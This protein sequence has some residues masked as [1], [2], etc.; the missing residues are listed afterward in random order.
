MSDIPHDTD[1]EELR[2]KILALF[3][4]T[5]SAGLQVADSEQ[6][7]FEQKC[8]PWMKKLTDTAMYLID[9]YCQAREKAVR[10]NELTQ[11]DNQDF[12]N[13]S[14]LFHVYYVNRVGELSAPTQPQ[15]TDL[16]NRRSK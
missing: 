13:D 16:V 4:D 7:L 1:R 5:A 11:L 12:L 14:D 3:K 8:G 10:I 9:N 2:A 15:P 6:E